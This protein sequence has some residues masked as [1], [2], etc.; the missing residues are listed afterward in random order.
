MTHV[1]LCRQ[2]HLSGLHTSIS[3]LRTYWV[4]YRGYSRR[5]SREYVSGKQVQYT[6]HQQHWHHHHCQHHHVDTFTLMV[7]VLVVVENFRASPAS[8]ALRTRIEFLKEIYKTEQT[9]VKN[10]EALKTVPLSSPLPSP[11]PSTS[12]SIRSPQICM[13][14]CFS[15]SC[16]LNPSK[17]APT[18]SRSNT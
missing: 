17:I 13:A 8:R 2:Y 4:K 16:S 3:Y 6:S 7:M 5:K 11:L 15:F 14:D 18:S 9:Y 12:V 10:L 1:F